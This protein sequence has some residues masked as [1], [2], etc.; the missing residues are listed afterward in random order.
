MNRKLLYLAEHGEM[1]KKEGRKG[2]IGEHLS[3]HKEL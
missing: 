1:K 2:D 3:T